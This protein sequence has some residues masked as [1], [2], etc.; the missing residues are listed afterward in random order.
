MPAEE[1]LTCPFC[2][3]QAVERLT[4]FGSQLMTSQFRCHNCRSIFERV[5]WRDTGGLF[6]GK[7][8]TTPE[9]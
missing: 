4:L 8:N 9:S 7:P 5:R 1:A 3:S 6:D 2:E